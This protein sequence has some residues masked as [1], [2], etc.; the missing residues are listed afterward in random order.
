MKEKDRIW[1][2]VSRKLAGEATGKEIK[3]LEELLR[4]NPD[5][6]YSVQLLSDVWQAKVAGDPDEAEQA[7]DRHLS[8]LDDPTRQPSADPEPASPA[9]E[10][11]A[12]IPQHGPRPSLVDRFSQ[13]SDMLN[14]YFK[15]AWRNLYRSKGF[16]AINISGLA[17]GIASA[18]V[19][20]LWIRNEVSADQFRADL[21]MVD[22]GL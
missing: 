5:L 6:G 21:A 12:H 9:L 19:L 8:R 1:T 13:K 7:F 16:S 11:S 10:P 14:H 20:L 4:K 2:L 18:I 3:E 17:I 22:Q 15:I